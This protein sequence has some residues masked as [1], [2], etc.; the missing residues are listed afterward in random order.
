[1]DRV[2]ALNGPGFAGGSNWKRKY[3]LGSFRE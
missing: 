2:N 1:M 3:L